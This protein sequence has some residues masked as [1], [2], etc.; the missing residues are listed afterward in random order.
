MVWSWNNHG[1]AQLKIVI[2]DLIEIVGN[3]VIVFALSSD[4]RKR[5]RSQG[6]MKIF[7]SS[8]YFCLTERSLQLDRNYH[9]PKS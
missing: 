9:Y 5:G 8:S 1:I 4:F 7:S 3:G 2:W 6:L